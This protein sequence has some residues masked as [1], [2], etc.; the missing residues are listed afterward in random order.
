MGIRMGR[1]AFAVQLTTCGARTHLQA[2]SRG[3]CITHTNTSIAMVSYVKD[4]ARAKLDLERTLPCAATGKANAQHA[5][6]C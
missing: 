1:H 6:L 3:R 5:M 2:L 4:G